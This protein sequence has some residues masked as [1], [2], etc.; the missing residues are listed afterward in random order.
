M[1]VRGRFGEEL[2]SCYFVTCGGGVWVGS[3]WEF[4]FVD[5]CRWGGGV[6]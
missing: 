2:G 4:M 1:L 6:N 3:D 5:A